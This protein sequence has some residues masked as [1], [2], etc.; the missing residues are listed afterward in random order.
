MSG[1]SV[2]RMFLFC[3]SANVV[4]QGCL[5]AFF[6]LNGQLGKPCQI[7]I[8]KV[9]LINGLLRPTFIAL[10]AVEIMLMLRVLAICKLS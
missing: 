5:A 10:G 8:I 4:A 6:M 2:R 3:I 1:R 7:C 9:L